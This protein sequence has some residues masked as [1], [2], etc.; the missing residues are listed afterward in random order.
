MTSQSTFDQ[1]VISTANTGEYLHFV[2]FEL[3]NTDGVN[4][5]LLGTATQ[6]SVTSR[7]LLAPL[8]N[9]GTTS[10]DNNDTFIHTDMGGTWTL[11]LDRPYSGTE[12]TSAV[13]YNRVF[14]NAILGPRA[15]GG[16]I[17]LHSSDG[18]DPYEIG[19][20]GGD[21]IQTFPI[22]IITQPMSADT[23]LELYYNKNI[24][25]PSG[26][27][28]P[29]ATGGDDLNLSGTYTTDSNGLVL[30]GTDATLQTTGSTTFQTVSLWFR[31]NDIIP[32][33]SLFD[34]SGD[35]SA[36]FTA[37]TTV[38]NARSVTGSS[39]AYISAWQ[40]GLM[41]QYRYDSKSGLY[42]H[43]QGTNVVQGLIGLTSGSHGRTFRN[44]AFANILDFDY[45]FSADQYCA[46]DV[47][48][49]VSTSIL[50][51][52]VALT[53]IWSGTAQC[54]RYRE[55]DDKFIVMIEGDS[56]QVCMLDGD[57][58]V[59]TS[60]YSNTSITIAP[61]SLAVNGNILYFI[62]SDSYIYSLDISSNTNVPVQIGVNTVSSTQTINYFKGKVYA[63]V[64]NVLVE[65]ETSTGE[66]YSMNSP[67]VTQYRVY[68]IDFDGGYVSY[69]TS[70]DRNNRAPYD[71]GGSDGRSYTLTDGTNAISKTY[72]D[73]KVVSSLE[74]M[75]NYS[76]G[77]MHNVV[78][79]LSTPSTSTLTLF[80]NSSGLNSMDV[81]VETVA[82]F[83]N[84]L[85]ESEVKFGYDLYRTNNITHVPIPRV[86]IK[87][88]TDFSVHLDPIIDIDDLVGFQSLTSSVYTGTFHASNVFSLNT[89][90]DFYGETLS[91]INGFAG[92]FNGN[93]Y[94]LSNHSGTYI[95]NT[96]NTG[97]SVNGVVFHNFFSPTL[98]GITLNLQGT[99]S[100][101]NCVCCGTFV[102]AGAAFCDTLSNTATFQDN[103]VVVSGSSRFIGTWASG[104][105]ARI[106]EPMTRCFFAGTSDVFI[107]SGVHAG[108][109]AGEGNVSGENAC[110]FNGYVI[111]AADTGGLFGEV[112][113]TP[114]GCVGLYACGSYDVFNTNTNDY[115]GRIIGNRAG[116]TVLETYYYGPGDLVNLS[117]RVHQAG[118]GINSATVFSERKPSIHGSNY[119]EGDIVYG[120]GLKGT[121][122]SVWAGGAFAGPDILKNVPHIVPVE[123]FEKIHDPIGTI[124]VHLTNKTDYPV[125]M[126]F[127][128]DDPSVSFTVLDREYREVTGYV[129]RI[130]SRHHTLTNATEAV[131]NPSGLEYYVN[132]TS[133]ELD[134][135]VEPTTI[136]G[137][138]AK[139]ITDF[140]VYVGDITVGDF[141]DFSAMHLENYAGT[142]H[143][144]NRYF[145]TGDIQY[146]DT[147]TITTNSRI[148]LFQGMYDGNGYRFLDV[149]I[150]GYVQLMNMSKWSTMKNITVNNITGLQ[151]YGF[152]GAHTNGSIVRHCKVTGD[153]NMRGPAFIQY[154][155]ITG[156]FEDCQV[157][158]SGDSTQNDLGAAFGSATSVKRIFVA[159]QP[160]HMMGSNFNDLGGVMGNGSSNVS[161]IACNMNSFMQCSRDRIGLIIGSASNSLAGQPSSKGFY[162]CGDTYMLGSDNSM[163][164]TGLTGEGGLN[165][166][167]SANSGNITMNSG[168]S[169]PVPA[170]R[171]TLFADFTGEI[172]SQSVTNNPI[173]DTNVNGNQGALYSYDATLW[174]APWDLSSHMDSSSILIDVPHFIPLPDDEVVNDVI[175]NI[176]IYANSPDGYAAF[177]KIQG[178]RYETDYHVD[179]IGSD[180]LPTPTDGSWVTQFTFPFA[181]EATKNI[182]FRGT[183]LT[184]VDSLT[185][186]IGGILFAPFPTGAVSTIEAKN[187]TDFSVYSSAI[188]TMNDLADF[189]AAVGVTSFHK[190]NVYNMTADVD[191]GTITE[192]IIF[193]NFAGIF[194]GKGYRIK[195]RNSTT[196][197]QI[198]SVS[199]VCIIKNVIFQNTAIE[200]VLFLYGRGKLLNCV[201]CGKFNGANAA[202]VYRMT[203][204]SSIERCYVLASGESTMRAGMVGFVSS[205]YIGVSKSFFCGSSTVSIETTG[206]TGC[207]GRSVALGGN[208]GVNF[209]GSV[210]SNQDVGGLVGEA[211]YSNGMGYYVC[212]DFDL[213]N[214]NGLIERLLQPGTS[215]DEMYYANKGAVTGNLDITQGLTGSNHVLLSTAFAEFS[216]TYNGVEITEDISNVKN[217]GSGVYSR[218]PG[219]WWSP[220]DFVTTRPSFLK[221]T[222]HF[223]PVE[224]SEQMIDV[225]GSIT[226]EM[227][228]TWQYPIFVRVEYVDDTDMSITFY[229]RSY[230]EITTAIAVEI[231]FPL[232]VT[233]N[234][235]HGGALV[236]SSDNLTYAFGVALGTLVPGLGPTATNASTIT[237]FSVFMDVPILLSTPEDIQAMYRSN[238]A[239][240]FHGSNTYF[241]TNDIDL[242]QDTFDFTNDRI[243]FFKGK[244]LGQG[245]RLS[246]HQGYFIAPQAGSQADSTI[247]DITFIDFQA[248]AIV[249]SG[250]GGEN[251]VFI[252]GNLVGT[253]TAPMLGSQYIRVI[254]DMKNIKVFLHGTATINQAAFMGQLA[255]GSE[256]FLVT[257]SGIH[258]NIGNGGG[259]MC[260]NG[261]GGFNIGCNVNGTSTISAGGVLMSTRSYESVGFTG[262]GYYATGKLDITR[263]N[264]NSSSWHTLNASQWWYSADQGGVYTAVRGSVTISG[265]TNLI[266]NGYLGSGAAYQTAFKDFVQG[267]SEDQHGIAGGMYDVDTTLWVTPWVLADHLDHPSMLRAMPHYMAIENRGKIPSI[268]GDVTVLTATYPVFLEIA[269]T[270]NGDGTESFT[271]RV[272]DTTYTEATEGVVVLVT[273][274]YQVRAG[275][276][277]LFNHETILSDD[278][279]TYT[280]GDPIWAVNNSPISFEA[281]WIAIDSAEYYR[282]VYDVDGETI[283]ASELTD[284]KLFIQNLSPGTAYTFSVYSRLVASSDYVLQYVSDASTLPN[285]AANYGGFLDLIQEDIS[286]VFD[287]SNTNTATRDL[288]DDIIEDLFD[289]GARITVKATVNGVESDVVSTLVHRGSS[290]D[291]EATNAILTS[292]NGSDSN[293]YIE[294]D[295][296][297]G[298]S[299]LEY[300]PSTNTVVLGGIAYNIGQ[301]VIIDGKK[302]KILES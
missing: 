3:Y 162:G 215:F 48:N 157:L 233:K 119:L 236:T 155:N 237:D 108:T 123:N 195:N 249:G 105:V 257:T 128:F 37:V 203:H 31:F 261:A 297:T 50:G 7:M 60:I 129:A 209:S 228:D 61:R 112:D 205:T 134:A 27:S 78:F 152:F 252:S 181:V 17:T 142:F 51:T 160:G 118:Q 267:I 274:P 64:A 62:G 224:S 8:G 269:Y 19:V 53:A 299:R 83:S 253:Q 292:F 159:T 219:I 192:G 44:T 145:Q 36:S 66:Q 11:D 213:T 230:V 59:F 126:K 92:T 144:G 210:S 246:N 282:I 239:G 251:L 175:C 127:N 197:N 21:A 104:V 49:D 82:T 187:V 117:T 102:T 89:D 28:F 149:Y 139:T 33:F 301:S 24:Q 270:D 286:G 131:T 133:T 276:D 56:D 179:L 163:R 86:S 39:S 214:G 96:L 285:V 295:T 232:A 137:T 22:N 244:L 72:I 294:L 291:V 196:F 268:L 18:L 281:N 65:I 248:C 13:F 113:N 189:Q 29:S 207:I 238:Y 46:V 94:R 111:G 170:G 255:G 32:S 280:L 41:N 182:I 290:V 122:T 202:L 158:A 63:Q 254:T 95:F 106:A 79:V 298:S 148:N 185:Y 45:R 125:F 115:S 23:S 178:D 35:A 183:T 154:T 184:S 150:I 87:D 88:V 1:V 58:G 85:Q 265:Q 116:G 143:A 5:A 93:G 235:Y 293:Q 206:D 190:K 287:L 156:I 55:S 212:G 259:V 77:N 38:T 161:K 167:F 4:I 9:D 140:S 279:T 12:L 10:Q 217:G 98:R 151:S 250:H 263:V 221:E 240:A 201:A 141:D 174:T 26:S 204:F 172:F 223:I 256:L 68:A 226:I 300:D 136:V 15:T 84:E 247:Q 208:V 70:N 109:L 272:L 110:N 225:L 164:T 266:T 40:Y 262:G 34:S 222:P 258:S 278:N 57:T 191:F 81:T 200:P 180:G 227:E 260:N 231:V 74:D 283:T 199:D 198:S 193:N 25:Q 52:R 234:V 97:A 220:W 186:V 100:M 277:V 121:D 171:G 20:L 54:L 146:P 173:V 124:Q 47:N 90:I 67:S 6:D 69:P 14:G 245:Y 71:F 120:V 42:M 242:H 107:Q 169:S 296:E 135:L 216:G 147:S 264:S 101:T 273:F 194:D 114:N 275:T 289:D 288:M 138:A 153:V 243:L 177:F 91:S 302:I 188:I 16:T 43:P 99:A 103:S 2:E 211:N 132:A 284:T 218:A 30:S 271:Y 176:Q 76:F 168:N 166:F 80:G 130:V 229:T 73:G 241:I 165:E 75:L